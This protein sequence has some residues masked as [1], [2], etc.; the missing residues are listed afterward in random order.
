[1]NQ[2]VHITALSP[3]YGRKCWRKNKRGSFAKGSFKIKHTIL[4]IFVPLNTILPL[5]ITQKMTEIN[6]K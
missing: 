5:E 2:L 3:Q 6:M 1:M 4:N